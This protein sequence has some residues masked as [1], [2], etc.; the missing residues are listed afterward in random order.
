MQNRY[1]GDVGDFAKYALL[2]RLGGRLGER[3]VRLGIA[4]CLFPDE[5]H[6]ED[7]RHIS[8]LSKSEYLGLDDELLRRLHEMVNSGCRSISSV[9]EGKLLQPETR[10]FDMPT[11]RLGTARC[12]SADRLRYREEWTVACFDHLQNC[13]LVFFDPDNGI[14]VASV[15]KDHPKAGKYIFWDELALFFDRGHSVLIYHH[16]NRS[17]PAIDQVRELAVEVRR[18]L[19]GARIL[20]LVFRRGSCR[21]FWLVHHQ[22][23]LGH[24]LDRRAV[25]FL[26]AGW[27]AHFRPLDW[28][29]ER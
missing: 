17:K 24:E 29:G 15:P 4:W 6:N 9:A 16:L 8:Y 22:T 2:R 23:T 27:A 25:D 18:R 1:T 21:V 5:T 11:F 26:K 13:D 20:P 7:G 3:P 19:Q 10:F 28:I 14:E 12:G